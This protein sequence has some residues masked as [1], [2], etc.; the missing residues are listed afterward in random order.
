MRLGGVEFRAISKAAT[1][2]ELCGAAARQADLM[3]NTARDLTTNFGRSEA[4]RT[5]STAATAVVAHLLMVWAASST[6]L[7]KSV[8]A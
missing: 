7:P 1:G 2:R 3:T 5:N 6:K 8:R 4:W